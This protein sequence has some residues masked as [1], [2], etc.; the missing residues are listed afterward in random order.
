MLEILEATS[1]ACAGLSV[2]EMLTQLSAVSRERERPV[3]ADDYDSDDGAFFGPENSS[4]LEA[5]KDRIQADL[6]ACKSAGFR[7]GLYPDT[8]LFCISIRVSKLGISS[9]AQEAWNLNPQQYIVCLLHHTDSYVPFDKLLQSDVINPGVQIFV[10]LC[11]TYKPALA[12]ARLAIDTGCTGNTDTDSKSQ[13]RPL[14]I[15]E[16]LN[17]LMNRQFPPIVFARARYG[18]SWSA[19]ELYYND[20]Q[21]GL[22]KKHTDP[23]YHNDPNTTGSGHT[24][25]SLVSADHLA[26]HLS[27]TLSSTAAKVIS[28]PLVAMQFALRHLVNCTKFC[29]VCHCPT[30]D[31]FEALKPYVCSNPLCLF[32]YMALG[33]GP[34]VQWEILTQPYVVDLLVSF[35]YYAAARGS[36]NHFPTGMGLTVPHLDE[37]K[38]PLRSPSESPQPSSQNILIGPSTDFLSYIGTGKI[39]ASISLETKVLTISSE[40]NEKLEHVKKGD[41]L[42]LDIGDDRRILCQVECASLPELKFV[43]ERDFASLFSSPLVSTMSLDEARRTLGLH[44]FDCEVLLWDSDFD[45]L[46]DIQKR[47]T[48]VYLLNMLPSVLDMQRYLNTEGT[49]NTDLAQTLPKP[50][51][52]LLRWIIASNRSCIVL[53][54][55]IEKMEARADER[56]RLDGIDGLLQF[57]FAQ[58]AP[59]KEQRFVDAVR[60]RQKITKNKVPTFYAWHGSPLHNWHSILREGL[61]FNRVVHGRTWGD[62]VYMALDFHTSKSYSSKY[63]SL[64]IWPQ[65]TLGVKAVV[66]LQEVVN[67]PKDFVSLHPCYVVNQTD[68]VQTRYLFVQCIKLVDT[69]GLK[70]KRE[71]DA[72]KEQDPDRQAKGNTQNK[73]LLLPAPEHDDENSDPLV[74]ESDESDDEEISLLQPHVPFNTKEDHGLLDPTQTDFIPGVSHPPSTFR[75]LGPPPYATSASTR[76]LLSDLKATYKVQKSAQQHTLGWYMDPELIQTP[77]QWLVEMHTFDENLPLARDLKNAGLTSVLIEINFSESHP[78]APPFVRVVRPKFL[79]F[80][81]GGGGHVTQGGAM[82]MELLTSNGWS[83]VTSMESVLLQIRLALSSVEPHPARLELGQNAARK[84]VRSYDATAAYAA[85]VRVCGQH[86]WRVHEG[87]QK[88]SQWA[89]Q[90]GPVQE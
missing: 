47:Q 53:D 86:G 15:G 77:Y 62:G 2:H 63:Q 20:R 66:S 83:P 21:N 12:Q 75:L 80:I 18:L 56:K 36:L 7:I 19:A 65:S 40:P 60:E 9:E 78:V 29:L 43:D 25:P 1:Q 46:P 22:V 5:H 32:Q 4:L 8:P 13:L 41:F 34:T 84:T 76:V 26:E 72:V 48:I 44:T 64:D 70:R 50:V 82:C 55:I 30:G 39:D 69:Q 23:K 59:D 33:F 81:M 6:Q 31:T 11:N 90:N 42:L 74:Y 16:S 28:L 54:D 73:K 51:Y 10:G 27:P 45:S 57:R 24:S 3:Q 35:A 68:W 89:L 79:P 71:P 58:G 37:R 49:K 67:S 88:I 14:F 85:Y 38:Y 52:D 87:F 17:N 61:N